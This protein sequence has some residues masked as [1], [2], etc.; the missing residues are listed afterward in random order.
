MKKYVIDRFEENFAVLEREGGGT[1]DI[2]KNLLPDAKKGD[3]VIE[4]DG[5]FFVNKKQSD[6]RKSLLEEKIR[7]LFGGK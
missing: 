7:R 4:K 3:V 2:E 1:I 6:E 5:K